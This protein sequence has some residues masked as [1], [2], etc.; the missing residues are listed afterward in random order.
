MIL[1]IHD[2]MP[3]RIPEPLVDEWLSGEGHEKELLDKAA[4]PVRCE[5]DVEQLGLWD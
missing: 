2:R 3:V 1:S 4:V 5:Q